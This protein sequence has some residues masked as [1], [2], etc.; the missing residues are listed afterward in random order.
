VISRKELH[1]GERPLEN[2]LWAGAIDN[3]GDA[4]LAGLTRVIKPYG[5]IACCGLAGG[6]ALTTT[7]MPMIIR[8]VSLLGIASAGTAR[9]Q[10]E[11]VWQRL[12]G[13]WKPAHLD[14]ICTRTVG[15]DELPEVFPTML[16]GGSFGR[17]LVRI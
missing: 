10:R 5:N 12:A 2:A 15:L 6:V 9:A 8:G 13:A 17:T 14:A 11:E 4:M 16:A 7:V 3:V 1:L